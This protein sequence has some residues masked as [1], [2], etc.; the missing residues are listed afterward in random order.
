MNDSKIK[1]INPADVI[2]PKD[3]ISNIEVLFDGGSES[4][5]IARL[6]WDGTDSCYAMRWNV[7]NREFD[8]EQKANGE[9]PCI[10]L[11][12]SHGHATWFM[13]PEVIKGY[14]DDIIKQEKKRIRKE[15]IPL[16]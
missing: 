2:S 12:Q 3:L 13:L 1:Y 5:S 16:S 4:F 9:I 6:T 8:N 15:H 7:S 14:I 10:G 11:P